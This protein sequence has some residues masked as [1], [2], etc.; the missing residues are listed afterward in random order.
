M[1][2]HV[3]VLNAGSSSLKYRLVDVDSGGAPASGL[4]E[5]IGEETSSLRHTGP[6]G[7]TRVTERMA[8][9]EKALRAV[10]ELFASHG[11]DLTSADVVAVGHRVVHGGE[12]FADPVLIDD[13]VVATIEELVP[14]APLHNPANLEGIRV[15]RR[16][17]PD[18]PQ[19]AVFDTAFHQTLPPVAY[20]YAVPRHWERKYSVRRFGFHGTSHAYVSR[21]AAEMLG[22]EP[23]DVNVITLHLGNGASA[24]AVAGGR[25][26][27]TSMGLTPLQGL[28]MGT[29][30]GDIDPAVPAHLADVAGYSLDEVTEGLNR[31]SGLLGLT[32]YNDMRTVQQLADDGNEDARLALDV[33]CYRIRSYVGAYFA[34]LGRVDAIVFTA[35][36]GE[37]SPP[38]RALSLQGLSSF[39]VEVDAE[40]ND[41]DTGGARSISPPDGRVA[42]LVVPTDE[43]LEIARQAVALL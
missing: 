42:V 19:V 35:G 40:R 3:L 22:R 10:L 8:D 27:D 6:R 14:L 39:G 31:R 23:A 32:G 36:I 43:E 21:V 41:A 15:A 26:V 16:V 20:T 1:S 28:V 29:R 5:R 25:S 7:E 13:A 30:S 9:H 34:V 4:V 38:V 12:R 2:R 24:T 33:Y 18:L 17:F 11:P 37:H